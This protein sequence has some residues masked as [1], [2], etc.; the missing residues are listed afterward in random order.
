[1]WRTVFRKE[2]LENVLGY[3]FP[4]F[5]LIS[6]VLVL[7][8][9]YVRELDYGKRV[10]DYSEQ[11]RLA[12][13]ELAAARPVDLHFGRIPLR[14]F[15]PPSPLAVF[16]AG[17]ETSLPKFYDFSAEGPKPG[18]TSVSEESVLAVFGQLDFLFIVLMVASLIVL[19][20]ASDM[21]AGEKEMGT[22]RVMLANSTPR[23]SVLWGKFLGGFTAVWLPFLVVFLVG[24]ILLGL[25]GFP[26][27][28]AGVPAR[29]V[30]LFLASTVFLLAYFGLG[31]LVSASSARSRTALIAILLVWIALQV[32][33]PRLSDMVAAVVHPVPTETVVSMQ[34]SVVVKTVDNET[35]RE[36]G[37]QYEALFG[38][39]TPYSTEPEPEA[40]RKE[41][42]AFKTDLEARAAERKASQLREIESAYQR[43]KARQRAIA[44]NLSL[45]SPSAAFT[46]LMADLCGTGEI[47]RAR[48]L[49]AVRAHQQTLDAALY[50][51]VHR[52]TVIMPSGSTASGSSIDRLIDPK[53]LPAFSFTRA[54]LAEVLAGNWGSLI[55]IAFWLIAPFAAA[56]VRFIKYDVR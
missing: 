4:L 8:S 2:L 44:L 53:S 37:R 43:E 7:T 33:L 54:G 41:W 25:L 1:M 3:R 56:Y 9:L 22:L 17:F 46:R 13:E 50:G 26:L 12:G 23:H 16:A 31:L 49:D 34:K 32:A 28:Q 51:H 14:G 42:E 40:Q 11:V 47:D 20:F 36:L 19:L 27:G 29:L 6:A 38:R 55:S 39:G 18:N 52:T 10:R 15:L 21:I 5:F 45:I 48:Y 24:A 30:L 35:A